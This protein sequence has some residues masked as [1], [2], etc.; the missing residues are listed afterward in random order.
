MGV[1]V[2]LAQEKA[3]REAASVASALALLLSPPSRLAVGAG[4]SVSCR[5]AVRGAE[6]EGETVSVRATVRQLVT[7]AL[8]RPMPERRGEA[9]ESRDSERRA[10]GEGE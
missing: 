5:E 3:E 10:E 2:A 1:R 6:E 4:E 7:V 9:V 8:T